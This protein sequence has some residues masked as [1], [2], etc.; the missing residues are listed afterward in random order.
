MPGPNQTWDFSASI[1]DVTTISSFVDPTG[2]PGADE[3]PNANLALDDEVISFLEVTATEV[4]NLGAFVDIFNDGNPVGVQLDPP[5]KII[6]V[7]VTY[8]SSWS[9]TSGLEITVDGAD[10]MV[11]SAAIEATNYHWMFLMMPMVLS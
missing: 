11:D 5:Q 1:P 2:L 7:P 4:F 10:L 9:Q 8:N 6:E 3:F